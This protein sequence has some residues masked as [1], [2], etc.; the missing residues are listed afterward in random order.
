VLAPPVFVLAPLKAVPEF[1]DVLLVPPPLALPP[2]EFPPAP[3]A[4]VP[5]PPAV[6]WPN[7]PPWM[8][9]AEPPL[10]PA[11]PAPPVPLAP[12]LPPAPPAPPVAVPLDAPSAPGA[13][14]P[15]A[16][17]AFPPDPVAL[18]VLPMLLPAAAP[19]APPVCVVPTGVARLAAAA[20]VMVPLVPLT[21]LFEELAMLGLHPPLASW[22]IA[23][24]ARAATHIAIVNSAVH[25]FIRVILYGRLGFCCVDAPK[26]P[27]TPS[28]SL[29]PGC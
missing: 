3:P 13:P 17:V 8:L 25:L 7:V 23:G 28:P 19:P 2:L 5:V 18:P 11:P 1:V 22:P 27:K 20:T 16:P 9:L 24:V 26:A 4:V 15:A 10:P 14:I 21:D 29:W 12:P 6:P